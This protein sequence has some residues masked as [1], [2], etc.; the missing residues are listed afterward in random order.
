VL[1]GEPLNPSYLKEIETF[2]RENGMENVTITGKVSHAEIP[3][4][5]ERTHVFV[6]ASRMEVQSLVIIEA[7]ASGTPVVGLSNE[8]VDELVDG[9]VGAWLPKDA[10]PGEFARQVERV[11]SLPPEEY[12]RICLNARRRVGGMDWDDVLELTTRAYETVIRSHPQPSPR[13]GER[14][15]RL[16]AYLPG[17]QVRRFLETQTGALSARYRKVRRVTGK[18]WLFAGMNVL[19]SL[20]AYPLMRPPGT[21]WLRK[22]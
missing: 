8:T 9:E 20:V 18:T 15:A 6:S 7:L 10:P 22:T 13:Q 1:V 11:C 2:I 4:Y 12:E 14:L 16:V 19:T 5:L 21:S 17:G 3:A